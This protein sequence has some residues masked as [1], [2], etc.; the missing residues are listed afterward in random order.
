MKGAVRVGIVG[1]GPMGRLHARTVSRAAERGEGCVLASI[2]D[3]HRGRAEALAAE[4]GAEATN[5]LAAA[6]DELDAVIVA[7]PTR[8]HFTLGRRLLERGLDLLVEKPLAGTVAEAEAL[9]R[10]A[11]E[12]EAILQVGHV[13]WFNSGWREAARLAGE[14]RSIS[15]ERLN[16]PGSRGLDI[17]VV[18]DFMLHDLDWVARLLGEEVI[19]LE[20]EG[21]RVEND[22]FDEAEARLLFRSGCRV[23]LRA[24]RTHPERRRIVRI[25]G[26][27][28]RATADLLTRRVVRFEP[29][30][31][32]S[33]GSLQQS[34]PCHE[35]D[36]LAAQWTDFIGACVSRS[37][38]ETDASVGVATLRLVERV[39]EAI[40]IAEGKGSPPGDD[41][42][43][44]SW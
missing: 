33:T 18:Q 23:H 7:V 34:D 35:I 27:R 22:G 5:D 28:G 37:D 36:P 16:P 24:S 43:A 20:A 41:D 9:R 3:R 29:R 6:V 8:S 1:A 2:V 30:D 44:F 26:E 25:E 12:R 39:R 32:E 17:D 11:H 14:A 21:R 31:P 10:L 42:P 19:E 4:F 15:V 40:T 13:E 38:P